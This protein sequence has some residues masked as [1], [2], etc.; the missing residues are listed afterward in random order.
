MSHNQGPSNSLISGS[1]GNFVNFVWQHFNGQ[2]VAAWKSTHKLLVNQFVKIPTTTRNQTVLRDPNHEHH[3]VSFSLP[4]VTWHSLLSSLGTNIQ[5][6]PPRPNVDGIP[7]LDA[8]PNYTQYT[9]PPRQRA[10]LGLIN[11]VF[12]QFFKP[13][14][15]FKL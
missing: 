15:Y 13:S 9:M 8:M 4:L 3:I 5:Y 1:G 7:S 14:M 11:F 6:I 10:Q 2:K 12:K